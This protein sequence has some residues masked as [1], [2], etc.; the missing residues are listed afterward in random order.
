MA[1]VGNCTEVI[2]DLV[3]PIEK[4]PA[5]LAQRFPVGNPAWGFVTE[6]EG[7]DP[8]VLVERLTIWMGGALA[9]ENAYLE[10]TDGQIWPR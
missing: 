1:N 9:V 10:P 5:P 4:I 6:V 7:Q 2:S 3:S 8:F